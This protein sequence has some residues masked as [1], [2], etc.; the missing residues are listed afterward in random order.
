MKLYGGFEVRQRSW[1]LRERD[2]LRDLLDQLRAATTSRSDF[3]S[4]DTTDDEAVIQ[5]EAIEDRLAAIDQALDRI[6]SD[7]YG[8]CDMCGSAIP[9]RRLEALPTTAVCRDCVA[10]HHIAGSVVRPVSS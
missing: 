5:A 3:E 9:I 8:R 2:R 10:L 4:H 1:L 7:R 6:N